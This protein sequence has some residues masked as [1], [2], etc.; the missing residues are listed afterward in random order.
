[1]SSATPSDSMVIGVGL[2]VGISRCHALHRSADRCTSP[3]S[4]VGLCRGD[5]PD[6]RGSSC[7]A[8]TPWIRDE[9]DSGA[10]IGRPA[11]SA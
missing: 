9:S 8:T 10:V 11:R 5:D 3:F 7:L 2:A 4:P 6:T 1:M